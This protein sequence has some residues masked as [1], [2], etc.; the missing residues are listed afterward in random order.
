MAAVVCN[1]PG[2]AGFRLER[3]LLITE[4]GNELLSKL[5][6]QPWIIDC[7]RSCAGSP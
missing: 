2:V 6:I 3:P 4:T 5:P 1:R 7:G